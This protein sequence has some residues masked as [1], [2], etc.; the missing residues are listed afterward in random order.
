MY[1][2]LISRFLNI[3]GVNAIIKHYKTRELTCKYP[4]QKTFNYFHFSKKKKK[5]KSLSKL[6]KIIRGWQDQK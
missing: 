2:K 5:Y 6:R 4:Q 3:R 1:K